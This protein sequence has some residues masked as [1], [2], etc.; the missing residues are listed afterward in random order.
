M[1]FCPEWLIYNVNLDGSNWMYLWV[2]LFFFNFVWVMAPCYAIYVS[3]SDISNAF[4]V[5]AKSLSNKK[6][7]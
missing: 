6:S 7:K 4:A 3:I 1:T 5:R 2:Y